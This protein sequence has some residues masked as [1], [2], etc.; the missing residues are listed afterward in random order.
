MPTLFL[1]SRYSADSQALWRAASQ[2]GWDV[3][4]ISGRQI[5]NHLR[6]LPA[7][8]IYAEAIVAPLLADQLGIRIDDP[9]LDWLVESPSEFNE[10]DIVE[11]QVSLPESNG[12]EPDSPAEPLNAW[13]Y[14]RMYAGTVEAPEDWS[15]VHDHSLYGSPKRSGR[16]KFYRLLDLDSAL[17]RRCL[18]LNR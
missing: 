3:H 10:G 9:S 17:I 14:L 16:I 15:A 11:T 12:A 4:R 2:R 6:D 8:I 18:D 5:P 13:E 1:T 7:P